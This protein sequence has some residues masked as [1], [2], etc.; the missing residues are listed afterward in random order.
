MLVGRTGS[1]K[2]STITRKHYIRRDDRQVIFASASYNDYL[3]RMR[4]ES[5]LDAENVGR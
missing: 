5:V 2:G 3:E 4:S 1:C